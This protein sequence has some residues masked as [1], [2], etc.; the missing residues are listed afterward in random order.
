MR[1]SLLI[2]KSSLLFAAPLLGLMA[3][4]GY[5]QAPVPFVSQPLVKSLPIIN[6]NFSAV[7]I[8]CSGDYAYQ[9][10]GGN[11]NGPFV[12]QQDF[13]GEPGIGWTFMTVGD[14]YISGGTGLTGPNTAF[15]PPSFS[16]LPFKQ[17]AFVQNNVDSYRRESE[18]SPPE[19]R[20]FSLS[21][22][23]PATAPVTTATRPSRR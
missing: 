6:P 16:G 20:I 5:A 10:F 12:P 15:N 8:A 18:A 11:C 9:A 1:K 7:P 13:N 23:V 2:S 21:T 17:A 3:V 22:S 14:P 19:E 4:F